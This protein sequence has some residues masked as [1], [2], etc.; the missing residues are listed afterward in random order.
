PDRVHQAVLSG[1]LSHLGLRDGESREFRGARQSKFMISPGSVTAK[2]PP[3]WVM[4]AELVE[5]NRLWARTVAKVE[6][7]WAERL[8]PH[9]L[10][11]SYGEPRWDERSG[12]A[13]TSERVTLYGLPIVASRTIG[14]DR[15][16]PALAREMFIRHALVAGEWNHRSRPIEANRAFVADARQLGARVRRWDLVGDDAVFAFYDRRIGPEVVSARHFDRWWKATR[17]T[18]PQLLRMTLADLSGDGALTAADF[19]DTWQHGEI[20]LPV[21]YRFE[22]DA[23]GDGVTVHI[24]IAVLNQID[25]TGFDWQVPGFR[26]DLVDALVRSLPKDVRRELNPLN[27]SVAAVWAQVRLASP[28]TGTLADTV[29]TAVAAV[30]GV[31]TPADAFDARN[32]DGHHR[33]TFS[34][35]EQDGTVVATG[36]DLDAVR[37]LVGGR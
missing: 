32:V 22:P 3:Q 5:T 31:R 6:P 2:R 11:R 7:E 4:A 18:Q 33:I 21:T 37:R 19:P 27:T 16:D 36:K 13:V 14:V 20:A 29:A 1:L 10:K 28:A 9:L 25:A 30:S 12:R 8:A 26:E 35:E 34:V 24:P 17:Q 23:P 15:L